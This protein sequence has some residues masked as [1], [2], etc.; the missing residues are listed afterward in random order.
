MGIH[1]KNTMK[2]LILFATVIAATSACRDIYSSCSRYNKGKW[3]NHSFLKRN[4]QKY[5]GHCTPTQPP[6]GCRD[7]YH[8][9]GRYSTKYCYS[10]WWKENCKKHCGLCDG[11]TSQPP[12]TQAPQTQAP[13]T[14]APQ[15]QAPGTHRPGSCGRPQVAQ[16]RVVG[17]KT[18]NAHSWPWQIGLH[19]YGRFMC[20]GS[21]VNSRWVV[22]AAHCIYRRSASEFTVKLGDHNRNVDE[23]EQTI[24]VK[25]IIAH[26]RY[27]RLNY[28]IALLELESPVKFGKHV[29]PVCLPAQ[30]T[31]PAVGTKCY[32]TGWGKIRHPG[33]SHYILQQL[34]MK[35]QDKAVCD[36][37]NS[38]YQRISDQML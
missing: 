12:Q 29:Q 23:G 19:R 5:C 25:R 27:G 24:K 36:R 11:T 18:A 35:V 10:T 21:V 33:G 6:S 9:C 31:K 13:Q 4:C 1:K 15:T 17:G 26:P 14:Q 38:K 34:G 8:S 22:T 7:K 28:D 2:V 32:I 16:S 20:G 3:C 37:K 30:G